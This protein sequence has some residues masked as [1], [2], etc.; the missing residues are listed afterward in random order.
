MRTL[1]SDR[2]SSAA[3]SVVLYTMI[4]FGH[5]QA[6]VRGVYPLGMSA[7]NS[8]VTP[9]P[10]FTYANQLLIYSRNQ[11]KDPDGGVIATGN[12]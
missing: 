9:E 4:G 10:G 3:L 1:T 11:L 8:G 12:N 7:T 5:A 6:Q 2:I